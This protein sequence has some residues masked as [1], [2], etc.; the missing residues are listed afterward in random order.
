MARGD[1]KRFPRCSSGPRFSQD[2]RMPSR[3]PFLARWSPRIGRKA[4]RLHLITGP[5]TTIGLWSLPIWVI[6]FLIGQG[7]SRDLCIRGGRLRFRLPR[8]RGAVHAPHVQSSERAIRVQGLLAQRPAVPLQGLRSVVPQPRAQ[9]GHGSAAR[10]PSPRER[11][12]R[13]APA[14]RRPPGAPRGRSRQVACRRSS[15]DIM[16]GRAGEAGRALVLKRR[17]E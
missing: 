4:A 10:R 8:L 7:W 16:V 2:R 11:P 15:D 1:Q 6:L 9:P 12:V 13:R 17:P 5:A 14:H 3:A